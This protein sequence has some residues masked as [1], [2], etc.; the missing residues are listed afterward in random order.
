MEYRVTLKAW[1]RF[2]QI[3]TSKQG[4]TYEE[5]VYFDHRPDERELQA[6]QSGIKKEHSSRNIRLEKIEVKVEPIL[7]HD[8]RSYVS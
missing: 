5:I 4:Y 7:E 8:E 3:E 2:S 1:D 6:L